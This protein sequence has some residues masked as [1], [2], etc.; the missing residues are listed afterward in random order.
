SWPAA[1]AASQRRHLAAL[2]LAAGDPT[3]ALVQ[4]LQVPAPEQR[5]GNGLDA[6]L[7]D[8]LRKRAASA[9]ENT[10]IAAALA[11][12]LGLQRVHPTDDHTGDNLRID[13]IDAFST[14][15]S[16]AWERGRPECAA[17]RKHEGEL[18]AQADLLPLYRLVNSADY[19]RAASRCD[20]GAALKD[21]S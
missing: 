5:P 4:W 12:R 6:T 8:A 11:V 3:S 19:M 14:A 10:T 20:F 9:S 18:R 16:G 7:V 17:Q 15:I 13:D 21:E 1:P 2:L